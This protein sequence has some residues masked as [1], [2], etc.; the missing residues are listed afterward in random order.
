MDNNID[1]YLIFINKFMLITLL[2]KGF[3]KRDSRAREEMLL[4]NESSQMAVR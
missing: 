2:E 1:K 3:I 4:L